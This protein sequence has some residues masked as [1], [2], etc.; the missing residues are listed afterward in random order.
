MKEIGIFYGS[1]TGTTKKIAFQIGSKLGV[2]EED[3]IDVATCAPSK[4][5]DYRNL[6]LGTSTWGN[7]ALERDWQSFIDGLEAVSL[8]GKK[9]ALFGCGDVRM[10]KTFCAGVGE[11]YKR[12][13]QTGADFIGDYDLVGYDIT[14]TPA[15]IDGK[16]VGLLLDEVN[17]PEA[18]KLRTDGWTDKIRQEL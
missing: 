17:H 3:I 2:N 5:G 4:T 1:Q 12:L 9:V 15:R 14:E 11:L 18:T 13:Q 8:R 7:G 10:K 6:I 16:V